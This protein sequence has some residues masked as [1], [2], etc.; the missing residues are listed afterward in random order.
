[1]TILG[2]A[3]NLLGY[4]HV[5]PSS[6]LSSMSI[7]WTTWSLTILGLSILTGVDQ[8]WDPANDNPALEAKR[9]DV[10]RA[11]RGLVGRVLG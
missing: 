9:F 3:A 2:F 1:V 8:R 7:L 10:W 11:V 4:V 5:V 6:D